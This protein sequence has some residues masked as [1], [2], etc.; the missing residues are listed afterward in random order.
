MSES[1]LEYVKYVDSGYTIQDEDAGKTIC[2]SGI[3]AGVILLPN[4]KFDSPLQNSS[5]RIVK[6]GFAPFLK[7]IGAETSEKSHVIVASKNGLYLVDSPSVAEDICVG[8]SWLLTGELLDIRDPQ[9][10][11]PKFIEIKDLISSVKGS[12]SLK[13]TTVLNPYYLPQQSNSYLL[14]YRIKGSS[15][16]FSYAGFVQNVQIDPVANVV[17]GTAV[18][19]DRGADLEVRVRGGTTSDTRNVYSFASNTLSILPV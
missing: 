15:S 8:S 13:F 10:Q 16:S 6:Q 17:T 4:V 19:P 9:P 12:V 7:I 1:N 14:E 5:V 11:A 2:Y 3:D 18:L